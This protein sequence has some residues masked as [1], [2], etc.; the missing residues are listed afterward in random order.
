MNPQSG[1][2]RLSSY[3]GPTGLG[4]AWRVSWAA[5]VRRRFPLAILLVA[6]RSSPARRCS[7]AGR[8]RPATPRWI[9][10]LDRIVAGHPMSVMVGDDGGAGTGT[11]PRWRGPPPPTRSCCS[12]WRCSTASVAPTPSRCARWA[13]ASMP[14]ARSSGNLYL[15]GQGDPEVGDGAARRARVADLERGRAPHPRPRRRG[16]RAVPSR[17]VRARVEELLPRRLHRAADGADVPRQRVGVGRPY[18]TTPSAARPCPCHARAPRPRRR[19]SGRARPRGRRRDGPDQSCAPRCP[20]SRCARSMR[21]HGSSLAQ[22]L[23]R[24]AR[25][26]ARLRRRR[27]G[28]DR[29]RGGRDLRVR[30]RSPRD[31][32]VPRRLGPVLREPPDGGRD[33]PAAVE[34]RA[35]SRGSGALRMALPDRGR[36]HPSPPARAGSGSARRPAPWTTSPR[37][38]GGSGTTPPTGGSSSRCSRAGW[39]STRRRIWRTGSCRC[40]RTGR[41]R[42]ARARSRSAPSG[43]SRTPTMW[44]PR[45]PS[46]RHPTRS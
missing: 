12:R 16:H 4:P 42:P 35:A 7:R 40:S 30:G 38:R 43:G 5:M 45:V 15:R 3:D 18:P 10:H 44:S 37:S 32:D 9:R 17:L 31:G 46:G 36:G 28:H 6:C 23:R 13:P 2:T 29:E 33:R 27:G 41:G 19:R 20:R 11:A 26:G 8:R 22:L 24:G 1:T 39:T 21:A 34:R 14:T 25:Q